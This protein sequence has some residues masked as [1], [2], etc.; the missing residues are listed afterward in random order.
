MLGISD[1]LVTNTALIL[2]LAG[3]GASGEVIRLAG[4]ASL[5]AG[6]FSM[7]VG[8]YL[9]MQAQRELLESIL[10][11]ER[12]ALKQHPE[13]ARQVLAE[14][15]QEQGV[16][17]EHAAAASVDLAADPNRAMQVYARVRLGINPDELGSAYGAAFSSLATF[18]VGALAPLLPYLVGHSSQALLISLGLSALAAVA[19]GAYLA[20]V[21]NAAWYRV[22]LR[23]LM[24]VALAAAVTYAIG[25]LF[26]TTVA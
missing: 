5:V 20:F 6:A 26:H 17:A 9:S 11:M 12:R 2:G 21:T 19:I 18:A 25:L 14:V 13:Q 7:A 16:A 1:G 24:L 10:Q 3:A 22:A 8:E 4:L 15:L 23:Q